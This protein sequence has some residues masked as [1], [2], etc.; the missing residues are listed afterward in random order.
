MGVT[1]KDVLE[2]LKR[3]RDDRRRLDA[4]E[5]AKANPVTV[6]EHEVL[7]AL[8]FR[9]QSDDIV[10][11]HS[12]MPSDRTMLVAE[13]YRE[14]AAELN[15]SSNDDVHKDYLELRFEVELL[16]KYV[17]LLPCELKQILSLHYFEG[18]SWPQ[19]QADT[20]RSRRNI[21]QMRARAVGILTDLYAF[22]QTA[23]TGGTFK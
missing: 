7:T 22:V 18:K 10:V 1:R 21:E 6:S 15:C 2:K 3:Y 13:R 23:Q 11:S 8:A 9:H 17:S 14:V 4:L 16:E 20:H 19:V 5:Y 12:G